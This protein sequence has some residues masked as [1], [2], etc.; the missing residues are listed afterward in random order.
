M[1]SC[2]GDESPPLLFSVRKCSIFEIFVTNLYII[3]IFTL[4][5]QL[6][7]QKLMTMSGGISASVVGGFCNPLSDN[8][9]SPPH[10]IGFACN[11]DDM[12]GCGMVAP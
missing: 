5:L 11:L 6:K 10:G 2:C 12:S 9:L 1:L 7:L 3:L 8:V 4:S